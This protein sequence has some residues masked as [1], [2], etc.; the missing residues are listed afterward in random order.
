[1]RKKDKEINRLISEYETILKSCD[2]DNPLWTVYNIF[3][4][5]LKDLKGVK[6]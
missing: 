6:S 3:I 4:E 2:K 5:E 1:M